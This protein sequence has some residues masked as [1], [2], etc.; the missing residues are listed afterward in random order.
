MIQMAILWEDLY[1]MEKMKK[2]GMLTNFGRVQRKLLLLSSNAYRLT[3]DEKYLDD[4]LLTLALLRNILLIAKM[5]IHDS[6]ICMKVA[7]RVDAILAEKKI[8]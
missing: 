2:L 1:Q 6:R 3:R 7:E 4:A 8:K 5:G